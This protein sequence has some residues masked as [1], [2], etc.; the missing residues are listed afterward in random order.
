MRSFI[1][2]SFAAMIAKPPSTAASPILK[3][4][5]RESNIEG[6][7]YFPY[8]WSASFLLVKTAQCDKLSR[9][10]PMCFRGICGR[11]QRS[12]DSL[13]CGTPLDHRITARKKL[14]RAHAVDPHQ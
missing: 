2:A 7:A 9:K 6:R 14:A 12:I 5:H 1:V 3:F 4:S 8:K 13:Q 11:W 10:G